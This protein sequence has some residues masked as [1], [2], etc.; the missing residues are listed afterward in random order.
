MLVVKI[1]VT[2]QVP[3]RAGESVEKG[4]TSHTELRLIDE[5]HIQNVGER[6]N[7]NWEYKI[8]KPRGVKAKISHFRETGY[9]LLLI[10]ALRLLDNLPKKRKKRKS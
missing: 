5:I 10:K 1:Y 8:K 4:R 2:K 6:G 3:I 9:R 7:G